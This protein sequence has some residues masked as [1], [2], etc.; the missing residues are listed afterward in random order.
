MK[1]IKEIPIIHFILATN[2]ISDGKKVNLMFELTREGRSEGACVLEA[3]GR[4][5]FDNLQRQLTMG[6]RQGSQI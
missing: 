1:E 2:K 5:T 4:S 3:Y 6:L